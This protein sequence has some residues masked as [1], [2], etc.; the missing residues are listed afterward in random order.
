MVCFFLKSQGCPL[1]YKS[2]Y[3]C[4][5]IG[6]TTVNNASQKP[7]KHNNAVFGEVG[8]NGV[9]C[10]INYDRVTKPITPLFKISLRLG[11]APNVE[12]APNYPIAP[13][14][15]VN[16]LLGRNKHYFEMGASSCFFSLKQEIYGKYGYEGTKKSWYTANYI[17]FGYRFQKPNGGI[18]LRAGLTPL[19]GYN[20]FSLGSMFLWGG[21]SV[22]YSF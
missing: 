17:R 16:L 22:G 19:V 20:E 4:S 15:E 3:K 6:D 11:I 1:F 12:I 10:S 5:T 18:F 21:L 7:I 13:L 14:I 2:F 8:G 9:Y